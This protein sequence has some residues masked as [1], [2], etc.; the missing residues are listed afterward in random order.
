MNYQ[1]QALEFSKETGTKMTFIGQPEYKKHFSSDKEPRYVFKIR[2]TRNGKQY[3]FNFGQSLKDGAKQPTLY[4]VLTC[5]TKYDVGD[6][7]NF[8]SD[9]GYDTYNEDGYN[10]DNYKTWK[11][12][13]KEFEAVERLFSDVIEELQEIQ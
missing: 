1:K 2:L 12:V 10:K 3:T 13:C 8:C 6:Y 9:F 4:D 7:E 5:L 11:A